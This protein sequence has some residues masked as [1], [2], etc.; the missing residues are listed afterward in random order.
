MP[1]GKTPP[2]KRRKQYAD[3]EMKNAILAVRSGVETITSAAKRFG[4]PRVTLHDKISGR[5][6]ENCRL[7]RKPLLSDSEE[8]VLVKWVLACKTRGFPVTKEQL[9]YSAG[10]M[11]TKSGKPNPFANERPGRRWYELFMGRHKNL[12]VRE[13]QTLTTSR[14]AITQ[15]SVTAWCDEVKTYCQENNLMGAF[16]DPR[17]LFNCDETAF[18][19][20][21]KT[22]KVIAA[23]GDKSVYNISGNT[24][25]ENV[26]VLMTVRA[27]GAVA[28]PMILYAYE[29]IPL[30]VGMAVP[31]GW[32]LGKSESGWMTSETFFE[33]MANTFEPYL[34]E[35]NI[36]RPV[37]MFMDGHVSHMSLELSEFCATKKIELVALLPN[38]THLLQPLDVA[39]FHPLKNAWK[40]AVTE[41]RFEHASQKLKKEDFPP[42]LQSVIKS[43]LKPETI[44]NGFKTC[45]LVTLDVKDIDMTKI[46]GNL[47]QKPKTKPQRST[48]ETDKIKNCLIY[49]EGKMG[50]EKL[51]NFRHGGPIKRRDESLYEIWKNIRQDLRNSISDQDHTYS[52]ISAAPNANPVVAPLSV[53][54]DD[55]DYNSAS[56]DNP[57]PMMAT[58][59]EEA[60]VL[61]DA[62]EN[63]N[64]EQDLILDEGLFNDLGLD[65]SMGIELELPVTVVSNPLENIHLYTEFPPSTS[66]QAVTS[67]QQSTSLS[68]PSQS[69]RAVTPTPASQQS[70][71]LSQPSQSTRAVTPTPT[72]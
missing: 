18:F 71:S 10:R 56:I 52:D 33:Y 37:I 19:L 21:P 39:V 25:K 49:L 64:F 36:P 45:G 55:S 5:Y 61:I 1:P 23:R 30:Q 47:A 27:D 15:E 66:N 11:L 17:R 69:T 32:G 48:E 53:D 34:T 8:E 9:I 60:N 44:Q 57:D 24:D 58:T 4:V 40:K 22:G 2:L 26:T 68:Q 59:I 28:P 3:E 31:D 46:V 35:N 62:P 70:T 16:K 12:A 7:G 67:S 63:T 42:M 72:S 20:S 54:Q 41:W 6:D 13:C 14:A 51:K 29:R 43:T 50:Q 65:L 38:A